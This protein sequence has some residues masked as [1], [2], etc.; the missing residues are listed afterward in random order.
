MSE[1]SSPPATHARAHT[2][3]RVCC[4]HGVPGGVGW[5]GVGTVNVR[6]HAPT[7]THTHARA[8]SAWRVGWGGVGWGGD[9]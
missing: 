5:G 9:C 8:R 2:H 6:A 7:H 1:Q 4:H 3:T